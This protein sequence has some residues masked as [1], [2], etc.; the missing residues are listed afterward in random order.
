MEKCE[1]ARGE[2]SLP[3]ARG[4][5]QIRIL[6]LH[7]GEADDAIVCFLETVCLDHQPEYEALSYTW[8]DPSDTRKISVNNQQCDITVSLQNALM[9]LRGAR[10]VRRVWADAICINQSDND[11]K[12]DQVQQMASVYASSRR[13]LAYIGP[14]CD[15]SDELMEAIMRRSQAGAGDE[16]DKFNARQCLAAHDLISRPYWERMWII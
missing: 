7:P 1:M 2:V 16:P 10:N 15:G 14:A 5:R 3:L 13:V 11:E 8:G 9:A 12:M 4:A 6:L